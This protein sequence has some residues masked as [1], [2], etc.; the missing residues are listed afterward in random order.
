MKMSLVHLDY[1]FCNS[2]ITIII[3]LGIKINKITY[4]CDRV[5]EVT[6]L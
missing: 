6:V 1:C 3:I 2:L 4:I 5:G